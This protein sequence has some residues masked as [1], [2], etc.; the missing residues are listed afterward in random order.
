MCDENA[1]TIDAPAPIYPS[2]AG[3]ISAVADCETDRT[4]LGRVPQ[5][6]PNRTQLS[7]EAID[8]ALATA[9]QIPPRIK[10]SRLRIDLDELGRALPGS[11]SDVFRPPRG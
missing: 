4:E 1:Q 8:R 9:A 5:P 10:S 3:A 11:G 6:D 7:A 2:K